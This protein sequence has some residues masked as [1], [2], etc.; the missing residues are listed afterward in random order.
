MTDLS[1]TLDDLKTLEREAAELRERRQQNDQIAANEAE[2]QEQ[3]TPEEKVGQ[4]LGNARES[5]QPEDGASD[6][7]QQLEI[8]MNEIEEAALE[9]PAL[10]LLTTFALGVIVGHL[11]TRR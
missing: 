7:V 10:A 1:G 2:Q 5:D 3:S 6:L 8:Y 11:F 9:R 4:E